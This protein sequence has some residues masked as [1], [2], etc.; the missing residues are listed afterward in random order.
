MVIGNFI[1]LISSFSTSD[2]SSKQY[3][4]DGVYDGYM[5]LAL[6]FVCGSPIE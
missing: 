6:S 3:A 1:F 2:K 5:M 4:Y